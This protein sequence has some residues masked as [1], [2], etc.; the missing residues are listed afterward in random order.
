LAWFSVSGKVETHVIKQFFQKIEY[1]PRALRD[2]LLILLGAFVQ[3]LT[4]ACFWCPPAGQ[5]RN[6]GAGQLLYYTLGWPIGLVVLLG[7]LASVHLSWRYL[8]G[9]RFASRTIWPSSAFPFS[10]TC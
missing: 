3:A 2:Y 5:R 1:T 8:G 4:C 9:P 7:N 10:L 6:S